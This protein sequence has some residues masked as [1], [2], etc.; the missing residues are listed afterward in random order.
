MVLLPKGG[1]GEKQDLTMAPNG[2]GARAMCTT[3][4]PNP[5]QPASYPQAPVTHDTGP[6]HS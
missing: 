4:S 6:D 5:G 2:D 1:E 3:P